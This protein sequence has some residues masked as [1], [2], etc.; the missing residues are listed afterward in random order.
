MNKTLWESE[1][2]KRYYFME[3]NQAKK[4]SVNVLK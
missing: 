1:E 4:G 3:Y 2:E